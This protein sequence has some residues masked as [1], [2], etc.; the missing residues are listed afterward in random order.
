VTRPLT[1]R[2]LKARLD[3]EEKRASAWRHPRWTAHGP[4]LWGT[5]DSGDLRVIA[6]CPLAL[7]AEHA[8]LYDPARALREVALKRAILARYPD[9]ADLIA[10][11]YR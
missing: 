10:E 4:T 3:E 6:E 5:A 2:E 11:V 9:A 1:R 8:A 7:T